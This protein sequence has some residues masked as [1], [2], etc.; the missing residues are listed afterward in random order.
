MIIP[1]KSSSACITEPENFNDY[2]D[3]D[4]C[5]DVKGADS[6]DF[7]DTDYDGIQDSMDEC[8]LERENY[9][10]FQDDDGCPDEVQY[11]TLGD[12]DGDGIPNVS[13]ECPLDPETYNM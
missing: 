10:K 8:P 6:L 2:L 3:W 11:L 12:A 4:G 1:S 13:D 7:V 9:N 5:P